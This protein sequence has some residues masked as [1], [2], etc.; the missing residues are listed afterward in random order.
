MGGIRRIARP[1]LYVR[2]SER[3]FLR[4]AAKQTEAH[5][6]GAIGEGSII[7][8]PALIIGHERIFIGSG[9]VVHPGAF[10]SVVDER[11]GGSPDSRLEIGDGTRIGF[12]M[13]IA[14]GARVE[15]G[16]R[17]LTADRVF[18]GDTYHEYRDPTRPVLDQGLGKPQ[19]VRVGDGAFLG[20]NSAV[21]PGVTIGEG[22]YVAANTVVTE[23]VPPRSLVVGNPGRVVRR[24][25][26]S[27]WVP[28][29]T[30]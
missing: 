5:R 14:C 18:I 24:W 13:V 3:R 11:E 4:W 6:L 28:A 1:P 16:A 25:D 23:D 29:P 15:I 12:D 8:P 20:I 27:G 21:L 22:G 10:F 2:V 7:F 17:V 30:G 19:P 9:V 26:G